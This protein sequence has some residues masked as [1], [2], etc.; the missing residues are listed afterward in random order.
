MS[1]TK[2]VTLQKIVTHDFRYDPRINSDVYFVNYS[3]MFRYIH[4]VFR[5]SFLMYTKV[6]KSRQLIKFKYLHR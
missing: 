4:I 6:T 1:V 3:D 2:H 5:G